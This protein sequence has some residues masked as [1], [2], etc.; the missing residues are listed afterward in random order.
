MLEVKF[1]L[2]TGEATSIPDAPHQLK[3]THYHRLT[4]GQQFLLR[5]FILKKHIHASPYKAV[6][7]DAQTTQADFKKLKDYIEESRQHP[8]K[9][10]DTLLGWLI[11]FLMFA[12]PIYL[13]YHF[14]DWLQNTY[15][16][17]WIDQMTK[18]ANTPYQWVNHILYGDYGVLSL[19][20]YS[21]VWA[22]PVVVMIG[23]STAVIDQTH[24]KQYVVWSIEPTMRK[25][26]L[27][28][29]D[30][31]PVLE[32]FG[33]NAAAITQA[34]SQCSSCTKENCMSIIS[35]GSSCS[36]QIGATL[37]LFSAAHHSWLFVPYLLLVFLGGI[38]HNKLWY[39]KPTTFH[40][41]PPI[42]RSKLQWP[43]MK[44]LLIQI[45]STIQMF[46]LQALP[47]FIAICIVVSI[48]SLTPIL[49]IISGIF[50]PLLAL[51]H[52]PDSMAPGILFSMIRKD[53]MLLFNFDHGTVL[54]ALS[55]ASLLIL[56]FFSSTFSSC[57]VTV[58]MMVKHLGV[59]K[60]AG[61]VGRQMTTAIICTLFLALIA[62]ILI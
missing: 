13:A 62:G 6:E 55:P 26:G 32:G 44:P 49:T 5:Q 46:L 34:N 58:S 45:W 36:Y 18:Q 23:I 1:N 25:I 10:Q 20:I 21:L 28:G 53:G 57:M 50:T 27:D 43:D 56:V 3:L 38:L 39:R 42:Y 17:Q 35:F 51:L 7:S 8:P 9:I 19:G 31:I 2:A 40:V 22:L 11:I 4:T 30:I 16:T 47:I 60:G 41:A 15:V 29:Q 14:S 54:Q 61:I 24:L 37:S 12:L 33:C 59:K 48:L 52:I